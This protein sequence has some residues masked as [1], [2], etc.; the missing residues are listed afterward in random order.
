MCAALKCFALS[1]LL[2]FRFDPTSADVEPIPQWWNST[3]PF[4]AR[5]E[6]LIAELTL[7][8]KIAL[9]DYDAPEIPRLKIP[10]YNYWSEGTH[11]VA[12]AG[13]ATIFPSPL[14]MAATFAPE[15]P[16]R[17][18]QKRAKRRHCEA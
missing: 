8:E 2:I 18:F 12:F 10:A 17:S 1:V 15:F 6:A 3:V 11:G 9:L 16:Y 4:Q 7:I 13:I 5:V 14:A